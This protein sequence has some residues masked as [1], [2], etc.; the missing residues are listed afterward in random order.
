MRTRILIR[1]LVIL[2][3][4]LLPVTSVWAQVDTPTETPTDTPTDTP[5]ETPT[6]TPP[7]TPTETPTDMPTASPTDA[8]TDTP[9]ETPTATSSETPT[10]TPTDTPT[11]SPTDTP[12]DTPTETPTE[13]PTDTP[14]ETPTATPTATPTDTPTDTPTETPTDTPTQT[15]T[16]TPTATETD[17]P[18]VTPTQ[19]PTATPTVTPTMTPT[20][21]PT[22]TATPTPATDLSITKDDGE[23]SAVPGL[24][25]LTYTITVGN[26]GPD[27]SVGATVSDTFPAT[28]TGLSWTCVASPGSICTPSGSG[29]ISDTVTVLVGGELTYTVTA[30]VAPDAT[31]VLDNTATVDPAIGVIDPNTDNN[32]ATDSDILTPQADV[33]ISITDDQVTAVPGSPISYTVTVANLGPSDVGQATVTDSIPVELVGA[34]WSCIA[35]VGSN[36]SPSGSGDID[37]AVD[38]LVGGTA[39]YTITGTVDPSATGDLLHGATVTPPIGVD[40]LVPENNSAADSD[41]L[42]PEADLEIGKTDGAVTATPGS[43]VVYIIVVTNHGPSDAPGTM[44]V[45]DFPAILDGATWACVASVG[46]NCTADGAGNINDSTYIAAGGTLTYTVDATI[47]AGATGIL[48]N[49]ASA[50]TMGDVT[51]PRP[52]NNSATDVDTLT[53]EADLRITKTDSQDPVI[54]GKP[55][56]YTIE[57]TNDGPSDATGVTMS[58]TLPMGVTFVQSMPAAPTCTENSGTVTC[59]LGSLTV[60]ESR[61]VTVDVTVRS[62]TIGEITNVATVSGSEGDLDVTNNTA[63]EAT[64]VD[65]EAD[66][67]VSKTDAPD[68]VIAGANLTYTIVVT[69]NGPSDATSVTLS[70][71]LPDDLTL[72]STTPGS[73]TCTESDSTITCDLGTIT[74]GSTTTVT[75]VAKVSDTTPPQTVLDNTASV[76]A[77]TTDPDSDNNSSTADTT[78]VTKTDLRL[79]ITDAPDPVVSGSRLTYALLV[80]N[81]GP[82]D[83]HGVTVTDVLPSTVS[84]IT[85]TATQGTCSVAASSVTCDLDTIAVDATATVRIAVKV[86]ATTG[87]V[88]NTAEVSGLAGDLTPA[89]NRATAQTAIKPAEQYALSL[90]VAPKSL[91]LGVVTQAVYVLKL[92]NIGASTT[93]NVQVVNQLPAGLQLRHALPQAASVAGNTLLFTFPNLAAGATKQV[94]IEAD[95]LASTAPGTTLIDTATLTDAEGH[96]AQTSVTGSVRNQVPKVVG[97][98]GVGLV[99]V[100]RVLAGSKM[101]TTVNITNTSR[102][103]A[104]NVTLTLDGPQASE[105]L[106][107]VPAPTVVQTIAGKSHVE[108]NLPSVRRN[109]HVK[110]NHRVADTVV[111]GTALQLKAT[112][113]APDGRSDTDSATVS[114]R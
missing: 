106:S 1:C 68:P 96:S 24:S 34:A 109:L 105:F 86:N 90:S 3:L 41:V 100:N 13:T 59:N 67:S 32:S 53:P 39:T 83:A 111:S 42:T 74:S 37:D 21:T 61:T 18:T 69:N 91:R 35:S 56:S 55:L 11:A 50:V 22:P 101:Q 57:V 47:D 2:A 33:G 89:D 19:T 65:A 98:L 52:D 36:C 102:D 110:V 66:L 15:P 46:S 85:V 6:A 10:E 8:P 71:T 64:T 14:T 40:D 79:R 9:T 60:G 49:T 80:S 78:V 97:K 44:V 30:A 26:G 88:V 38:L 94:V 54:A 27:D 113:S 72:V 23:L 82:A 63:E 95:L 4:A 84:L 7:E 43:A 25:V 104:K 62:A 75:I 87:P 73:P 92:R 17:T 112:V 45:D 28:L 20:D 81:Q 31:G 107:A 48:S 5:T 114:V 29:D 58:D 93:T 76:S 51:D 99:T 12:T 77:A 108:W 103:D 16:Q 70:D